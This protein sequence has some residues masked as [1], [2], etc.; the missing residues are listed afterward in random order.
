MKNVSVINKLK[1]GLGMIILLSLISSFVTY[2]EYKR[3]EQAY[4]KFESIHHSDKTLNDLNMMLT[5]NTL[6]YMDAIVDKDSADV[7]SEIVKKHEEFKKHLDENKNELNTLFTSIDPQ[8]NSDS[9]FT[10]ADTYWTAAGNMFKDIKAKQTSDLGKYDDDIDGI[11]EELQQT[12]FNFLK[13]TSA[14]FKTSSNNLE[15]AQRLLLISTIVS[16]LS[17]L[18]AGFLI[19]QFVIKSIS[20]S[21][22]SNSA[23]LNDG[24]QLVL[25][26]S[27]EFTNLGD[28]LKNS[29]VIQASSLQETVSAMDEIKATVDKNSDLSKESVTFADSCVNSSLEGKKATEEMVYTVR[30]IEKNQKQNNETL[31]KTVNEIK[32]MAEVIKG[33]SKKTEVINDIVFQTKLLSFNASVEAARAGEH[34]KGFAVVAEE[35]GNLASMSGNAAR[36]INEMLNSS[37]RTVETLASNIEAT[38]QTVAQLSTKSVEKGVITAQTCTEALQQINENVNRMKEMILEI[39]N[40]SQ[41]QAIGIQSIQ[42]AMN[43]LDQVTNENVISAD[44]CARA[45]LEL[46]NQSERLKESIDNMTST[47]VG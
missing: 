30:E 45:S 31:Q 20:T 34:G 27:L 43:Q 6:G 7:D 36:E 3:I 1:I 25:N 42:L 24:A 47:L 13:L 2:I 23:I 29:T 33:I 15:E 11:N 8:F 32:E 44:Q 39:N 41:E 10:K 9:F 16:L 40:S 35:V 26:R 12:I 14:E 28:S 5:N 37:V 18:L 4:K 38:T 46:K 21:I 22:Q 19:Y 17:I